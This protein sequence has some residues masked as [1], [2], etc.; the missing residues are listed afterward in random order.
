MEYGQY[1]RI[2]AE[3]AVYMTILFFIIV[4]VIPRLPVCRQTKG[5]TGIARV[6]I[7]VP[8]RRQ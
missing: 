7:A 8:T 6:P 2:F 3:I 4:A 5:A 1:A